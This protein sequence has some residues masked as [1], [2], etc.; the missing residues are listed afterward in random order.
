L[1]L[2]QKTNMSEGIMVRFFVKLTAMIP[3]VP[4]LSL[5]YDAPIV[6][7]FIVRSEDPIRHRIIILP[8]LKLNHDLKEQD[9][10]IEDGTRRQND[11]IE[12]MIRKYPHQW[13]WIHR[14]WSRHYPEIYR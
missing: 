5:K 14:K 2:D 4:A 8:E 3:L 9:K 1:L 12:S 11:I 7:I 13:L 10:I 6:P